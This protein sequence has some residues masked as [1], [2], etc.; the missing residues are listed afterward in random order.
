[1]P[2]F[3]RNCDALARFFMWLYEESIVLFFLK[4]LEEGWG[5]FVG[6]VVG[7]GVVGG[8]GDDDVI[9]EVDVEKAGGFVEF[10]G[11]VDVAKCRFNRSVNAV[12]YEND[13][14]SIEFE[15]L[16]ENDPDIKYG[17]L[18]SYGVS[19]CFDMGVSSVGEDDP[20]FFMFKT[21]HYRIHSFENH[22]RTVK[23]DVL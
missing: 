7:D 8:G 10:L 17:F 1:M 22:F 3:G 4:G 14:S 21:F 19:D 6:L 12:A 2:D 13:S 5:N 23:C 20:V 11:V 9:G 18:T 16:A 15:S